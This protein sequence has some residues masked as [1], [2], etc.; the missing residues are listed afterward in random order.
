ME[1]HLL[2]LGDYLREARLSLGLTL[3]AVEKQSGV[4]NAYISLIERGIQP[5][6]HPDILRKLAQVYRLEL[7]KLMEVAGYLTATVPPDDE[8]QEVERLFSEAISDASFDYGQRSK[9]ISFDYPTKKFIAEM[10]KRL[11]ESRAE[12]E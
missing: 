4:S 8:R 7:Q 9:K 3:R 2:N 12:N 1:G 11:K 10:Y 5:H 6:P